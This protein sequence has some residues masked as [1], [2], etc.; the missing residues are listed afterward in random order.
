MKNI[1]LILAILF[2]VSTETT[3]QFSATVQTT[4]NQF[5]VDPTKPENI[6]YRVNV[7]YEV[8]PQVFIT[9]GHQ[10]NGVD[11]LRN[12]D[13]YTINEHCSAVSIGNKY[14]FHGYDPVYLDDPKTQTPFVPIDST[15]RFYVGAQINWYTSVLE[16]TKY[17]LI[18]IDMN[19]PAIRG[20]VESFK[21]TTYNHVGAT[22]TFGTLIRINKNIS[23]DIGAG[24]EYFKS[25]YQS[26]ILTDTWSS[27]YVL[28]PAIN[29]GISYGL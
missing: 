29:I 28:W 19:T 20:E 23:T 4:A 21:S 11:R 10:R 22:A 14:I 24:I 3:A 15:I 17:E 2:T 7:N 1:L 12:I 25:S 6:S 9:L 16:Q 13:R 5:F 27:K 18:R 8:L 26:D